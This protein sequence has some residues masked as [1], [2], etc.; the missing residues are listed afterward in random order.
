[1][2]QEEQI[3]RKKISDQQTPLIFF[4]QGGRSYNKNAKTMNRS[5]E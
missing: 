2:E 4:H 5:F 3:S 1:L